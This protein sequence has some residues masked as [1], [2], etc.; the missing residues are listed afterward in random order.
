MARL[1]I[2]TYRALRRLEEFHESEELRRRAGALRLRVRLFTLFPQARIGMCH[3]LIDA[4]TFLYLGF[5]ASLWGVESRKKEFQVRERKR[6]KRRSAKLARWRSVFKLA[7][8]LKRGRRDRCFDFFV[9]TDGVAASLLFRRSKVRPERHRLGPIR[10][11]PVVTN[12]E[13]ARDVLRRARDASE[14]FGVERTRVI[15]IDPGRRDLVHAVERVRAPALPRAPPRAGGAGPRAPPR[16]P[17]GRAPRPGSALPAHR[18]PPPRSRRPASRSAPGA[19]SRPA[20]SGSPRPRS[21]ALPAPGSRP[22]RS[23]RRFRRPVPPRSRRP[24]PPRPTATRRRAPRRPRR[25]PG[26][27]RRRPPRRLGRPRGNRGKARGKTS[28]WRRRKGRRR[29]KDGLPRRHPPGRSERRK[30]TRR[31]TETHVVHRLTTA[32]YYRA[33]GLDMHQCQTRRRLEGIAAVL[34]EYGESQV[35]TAKKDSFLNGRVAAYATHSDALWAALGKRSW[36]KRRLHLYGAKKRVLDKFV[37]SLVPTRRD[38]RQ[39]IVGYGAANYASGGRGERSTP[40]K[41][42]RRLFSQKLPT[43]F[44]DEMNS[45]KMCADCRAYQ[46]RRYRQGECEGR[47]VVQAPPTAPSRKP[48]RR[49][50][51]STARA[52]VASAR[53][54]DAESSSATR[55]RRRT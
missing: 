7:P 37:Q 32:H 9:S 44:V 50:S 48:S 27:R 21:A 38:P 12:N 18:D 52:I 26:A 54:A 51:R 8:F 53:K 40:V 13:K 28:R 41:R 17:G 34:H 43:I 35:A 1:L 10:A 29:P 42:V 6:Y 11:D 3:V 30:A 25:A 19:R 4:N 39:V 49:P 36:A 24:A 47:V 20:A 2:W 5:G 33:S 22:P 46:C 15:A 16:A 45:T 23:R 55:T 14:E 31:A